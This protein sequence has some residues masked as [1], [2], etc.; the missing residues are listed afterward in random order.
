M[1]GT[2]ASD[3]RVYHQRPYNGGH[4]IVLKALFHELTEAKAVD[5]LVDPEW[6]G[7]VVAKLASYTSWYAP[8]GNHLVTETIRSIG[9]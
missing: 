1:V 4:V 9:V 3:R 8:K 2:T 7:A 5:R 6:L